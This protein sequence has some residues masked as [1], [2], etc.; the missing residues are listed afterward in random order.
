MLIPHQHVDL[1]STKKG[2]KMSGK[3]EQ[4]IEK[5]AVKKVKK[6]SKSEEKDK[7]ISELTFLLQRLQADFENHKKRVDKEKREYV[8][9]SN[10]R[11][12][13]KIIPLVDNFELGLKNTGNSEEFLKGM[14]LI[15]G[16]FID[17]LKQD[18]VERIESLNKPFNPNL[19]QA[20]MAEEKKG[21][22]PNTVIEEFQPGYKIKD[23]VIMLAKVK[24]SK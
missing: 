8:V 17:V 4:K 23:K 15:Y 6:L 24:V 12:F 22:E 7:K 13:K 3:K 5:E 21:V 14:E 16:Q 20:L 18:N 9:F 19:H 11:L 1:K 10:V 2:L